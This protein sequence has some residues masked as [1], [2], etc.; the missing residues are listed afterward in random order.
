MQLLVNDFCARKKRGA[1][2]KRSRDVLHQLEH[3]PTARACRV[4]SGPV[5]RGGNNRRS[6]YSCADCN[7]A[8]CVPDC[9]NKHIQALAHEH[10]ERVDE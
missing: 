4:C 2:A 6:H 3:S 5:G 10:V 8:L 9:Y 1:A 7:V